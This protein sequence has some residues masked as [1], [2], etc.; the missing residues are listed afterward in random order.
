MSYLSASGVNNDFGLANK[1]DNSHLTA[2]L[3]AEERICSSFPSLDFH[4]PPVSIVEQ[5]PA[6]VGQES[7]HYLEVWMHFP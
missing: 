1:A 7:S 5:T 2:T 4:S 6:L 3:G